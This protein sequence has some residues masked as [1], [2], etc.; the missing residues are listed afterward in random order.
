MDPFPDS[1]D[2]ISDYF[3]ISQ[4]GI[5]WDEKI[6]LFLRVY[7]DI[8]KIKAGL[9]LDEELLIL[10]ERG[11]VRKIRPAVLFGDADRELQCSV[12]YMTHSSRY[13]DWLEPSK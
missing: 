6:L 8:R 10:A 7:Y 11:P 5:L 3:N 2:E 12:F 4:N 1:S 13:L 9:S